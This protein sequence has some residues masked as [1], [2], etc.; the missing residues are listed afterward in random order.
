MEDRKDAIT[1]LCN[2]LG[3]T[4]IHSNNPYMI[5]FMEEETKRRVNIYFTVMTV[6]IEDEEHHQVHHKNVTLERLELILTT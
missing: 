6:T 3:W 4:S 5:S 2:G 1:E